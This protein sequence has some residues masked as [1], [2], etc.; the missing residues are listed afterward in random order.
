MSVHVLQHLGLLHQL[1]LDQGFH[2]AAVPT[3][4][5]C[6]GCETSDIHCHGYLHCLWYRNSIQWN[7]YLHSGRCLLGPHEEAYCQMYQRE[8]VST[9]RCS[10]RAAADFS[11]LYY[12][13]ASLNV[14]TDLLIGALPVRAVWRL[15]LVLKQKMALIAILSLGWL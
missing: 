9:R 14:G 11:R 13:N 1:D 15:Q 7:L 3:H 6:Q 2:L 8:C 12:A 10:K 5:F 4:L